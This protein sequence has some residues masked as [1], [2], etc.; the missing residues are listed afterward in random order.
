MKR[1]RKGTYSVRV[2]D[3]ASGRSVS[4]TVTPFFP[5]TTLDGVVR[6]FHDFAVRTWTGTSV[7]K[8]TDRRHA[9]R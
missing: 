2:T 7:T 5:S 4:F 8:I 6:D 1:K 9:R 3:N